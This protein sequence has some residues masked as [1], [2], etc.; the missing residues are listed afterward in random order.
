MESIILLIVVLPAIKEIAQL[1]FKMH[2]NHVDLRI[3]QFGFLVLSI[4]CLTMAFVQRVAPF[5]VGLLVFTLGVSTRPALQSV[6]TDLVTREQIAVMYTIAA[7]GDGIGA[8]TGSLVLNRAFAIAIG[9]GDAV[10]LG[11]PFMIAAGCY[12]VGFGA[13]SFAGHSG[14]KKKSGGE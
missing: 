1:K 11:L 12:G 6:L 5:I 10:W 3:V 8:A 2:S 13:T 9:W 14:L 7:V 4:G